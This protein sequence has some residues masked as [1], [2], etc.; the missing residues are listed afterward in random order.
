M[1]VFHSPFCC[2]G[3]AGIDNNYEPITLHSCGRVP[4]LTLLVFDEEQVLSLKYNH[5]RIIQARDKQVEDKQDQSMKGC[6]HK[7]LDKESYLQ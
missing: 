3:R 4:N 6:S 5:S 1:I 7:E 2:Y